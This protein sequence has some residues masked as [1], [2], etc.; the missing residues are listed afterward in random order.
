MDGFLIIKVVRD[1]KFAILITDNVFSS[2]LMVMK[3]CKVIELGNT[4]MSLNGS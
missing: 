3:L 2:L 1:K 4:W